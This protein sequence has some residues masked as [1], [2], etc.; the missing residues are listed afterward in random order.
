MLG[1]LSFALRNLLRNRRRSLY[2]I[3]AVALGFAAVNIFGG[4]TAYVF[5]NLRDS[6]IYAGGQGHLTIFRQE[7]GDSGKDAGEHLLLP[8]LREPVEALLKAQPEVRVVSPALAMQGMISNGQIS[9]V[10]VGQAALP[11]VVARIRA[12]AQGLV[13]GIRM[14]DGEPLREEHPVAIGAAG[15]M[16]DMLGLK[17]GEGAILIA[18]TIA[19]Q[20]NALDVDIVQT[21][22]PPID[23]L[24]TKLI[25]ATLPLA[26]SLYDTEG[27]S[28]LNV[29]LQRDTDVEPFR[30]RLRALF[31]ERGL[32]VTVKAWWELSPF[33]VKVERMFGVIFLFIFG[34]VAII[35]VMSVV[36]TVSMAVLERTREV[37]TMRA[38]GMREWG[39]VGLFAAE[40]GLLGLFGALLGMLLLAAAIEGVAH[41]GLAWTPPQLSTPVP[42]EVYWVP[43]Y[44]VSTFLILLL[45]S[46]LA[47][48]LPARRVARSNIVESLEHV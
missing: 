41:S 15:G 48:V 5:N 13:A 24:D 43:L 29:L 42:L 11:S 46:V 25:A 2:T 27:V 34:V 16:L 14:F 20:I 38:L 10:F 8:E 19:G 31:R 35:V 21:V 9:T 37:G 33:T 47:A 23:L 12:E 26:Q 40:S 17:Q 3:L 1:W 7:G 36:N 28:R 32:P 44:Q 4:F 30:E 22:H 45:L 6:Y 18:P 39:V